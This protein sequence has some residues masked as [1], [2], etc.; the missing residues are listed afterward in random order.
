MSGS[1][2]LSSFTPAQMLEKASTAGI[3]KSKLD[4]WPMLLLAILAGM[5]IAFGGVFPQSWQPEQWLPG[6]TG[7]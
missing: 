7:W 6:H 3:A 2:Q 4:F 1:E 5:Y